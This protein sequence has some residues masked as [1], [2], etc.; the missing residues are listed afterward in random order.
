MSG[1]AVTPSECEGRD[2][3]AAVLSD[4]RSGRMV[5]ICDGEGPESEGCLLAAAELV[6]AAAI[7][8]MTKEARGVV[9]LPLSAE[10]CD[11]LE[12]PAIA[13]RGDGCSGLDFTVS[14]EAREGVTTG[15]STE[16][17]ARTIHAAVA[18]RSE[19][20]DLVRP[21]H[22]FPLRAQSGGVLQRAGRAETAVDLARLAGLRPAGVICEILN[23]DGS[24]ATREEIAVYAA[25]HG[26]RRVTIGDVIAHRIDA[27]ERDWSRQSR[28]V[29]R[30][31]RA[32]QGALN[33]FKGDGAVVSTR[34]ADGR[35]VVTT[36]NSLVAVSLRPPLLVLSLR[37]E[38]HAFTNL[39]MSHQ[40]AISTPSRTGGGTS[41][42][43]CRVD[44]IHPAGDHEIV[45]GE[46]LYEGEDVIQMWETWPE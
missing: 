42:I 2:L 17:R 15:I 7:N 38:S 34:D 4:L 41:T 16:D 9:C 37:R 11:E 19:A 25:R 26:L 1:P 8:F 12:L 22:V 21:G 18:P 6:T 35:R 32:L 5:I 14:I 33:R 10:R 24:A 13:R 20:T 45:I 36:V 27:G 30:S 43:I 3:I 28:S 23:A 39:V 40:F 31:Q 44:R 29:T 46:A